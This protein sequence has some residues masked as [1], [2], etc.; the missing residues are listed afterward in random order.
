MADVAV[1]GLPDEVYGQRVV[2]AIV[3]DGQLDEADLHACAAAKL[4]SYKVPSAHVMVDSLPV[5]STTGKVNRREVAAMLSE[6]S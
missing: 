2:A 4:T 1:V 3:S 6:Y 5:N